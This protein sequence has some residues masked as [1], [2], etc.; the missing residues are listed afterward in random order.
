VRGLLG[1]ADQE[2]QVVDALDGEDVGGG[3]RLFHHLRHGLT[4]AQVTALGNS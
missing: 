2:P 3:F 4:L 1:V